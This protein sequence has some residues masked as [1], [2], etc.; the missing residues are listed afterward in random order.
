MFSLGLTRQGGY[1]P[2]AMCG[3]RPAIRPVAEKEKRCAAGRSAQFEPAACREPIEPL[4]RV[5]TAHDRAESVGCDRFLQRPEQIFFLCGGD[6]QH[7]FWSDAETGEALAV[8]VSAFLRLAAR[9][10]EAEAFRCLAGRMRR[11][12]QGKG[13]RYSLVA[14]RRA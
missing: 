2:A 11:K 8:K 7:P 14:R 10:A 3:R 12:G 5:E 1:A 13:E 9:A 6:H 4:P